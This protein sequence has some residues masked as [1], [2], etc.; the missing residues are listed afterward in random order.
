M[1]CY[2]CRGVSILSL[3]YKIL[4]NMLLSRTIPYANEIIRKYQYGVKR[5]ESIIDINGILRKHRRQGFE[6]SY[7]P[8]L[9]G[10]GDQKLPNN[11]YVINE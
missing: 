8:L 9:G 11:P 6:N 4:P 2:I 1:D 5:N 10:M 7:V 3:S